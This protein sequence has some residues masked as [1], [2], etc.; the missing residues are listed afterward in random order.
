MASYWPTSLA[1]ANDPIVA[2]KMNT[3]PKIVFSRSLKTV[4][5]Q[6]TR[7]VNENFN[8]EISMLKHATNKDHII[9]GSSGLTVTL[10]NQG[11][12]DEFRIM[13]NPVILGNGKHLFIGV[14]I[15][16]K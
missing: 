12:V 1:N 2:E 4:D 5:W 14:D 16:L 8:N 13:L 11:L 10:I 3:M 15:K 9:F 6:N 7:L